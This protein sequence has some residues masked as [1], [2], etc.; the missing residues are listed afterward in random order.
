[1]SNITL[2]LQFSFYSYIPPFP[3]LYNAMLSLTAGIMHSRHYCI[4]YRLHLFVHGYKN[5]VICAAHLQVVTVIH[6]G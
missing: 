6:E 1:M 4:P 5:L 3:S 2:T